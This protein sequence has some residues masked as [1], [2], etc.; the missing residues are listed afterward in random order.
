[1]ENTLARLNLNTALAL[2]VAVAIAAVRPAW[3]VSSLSF[4]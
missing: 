3:R 1:M 4:T 2:N